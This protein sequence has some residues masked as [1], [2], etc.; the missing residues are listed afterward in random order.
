MNNEWGT[1]CG[2]TWGSADATVVCQQ[3]GYPTQGQNQLETC[4]SCSHPSISYLPTDAV[5]FHFGNGNGQ[6]YL[7]NVDCTGSESNLLNCSRSSFVSCSGGH[8]WDAGVR[9]QGT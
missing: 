8:S 1:V 5:A 7:N 6:I 4:T 9:S 3:L 2:E